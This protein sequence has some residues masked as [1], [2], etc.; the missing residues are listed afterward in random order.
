MGL[1]QQ[2]TPPTRGRPRVVDLPTIVRT[3]TALV[4]KQGLGGLT[5]RAVADALGVAPMTLY[6]YVSDKEALV[7]LV[8]A[9]LHANALGDLE[10]FEQWRQLLLALGSATR[11]VALDHP[12]LLDMYL[13]TRLSS[14]TAVAVAEHCLAMMQADGVPREAG[15]QALD[16]VQLY[17][18][19]YVMREAGRTVHDRPTRRTRGNAAQS[20]PSDFLAG[21]ALI[22]NGVPSQ[23]AN[24]P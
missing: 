16:T 9:E 7:D 18:L 13:H 11:R 19:G 8:A 6:G 21:L 12:G 17:V 5:V 10:T 4:D 24:L 3:A 15:L 22:V 2:A 14:P 20:E 23:A 1:E